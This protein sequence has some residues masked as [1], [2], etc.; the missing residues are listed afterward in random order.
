LA[1]PVVETSTLVGN[2]ELT[3]VVPVTPLDEVDLNLSNSTSSYNISYL[4]VPKSVDSPSPPWLV[5]VLVS[6]LLG[7]KNGILG[8]LNF[9]TLVVPL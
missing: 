5:P 3:S 8:F 6:V 4:G 1:T 9:L 2:L 7:N